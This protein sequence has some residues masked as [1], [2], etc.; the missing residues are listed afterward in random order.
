ME[1]VACEASGGPVGKGQTHRVLVN[2]VSYE[3]DL[4]ACVCVDY[5]TPT[6]IESCR[7]ELSGFKRRRA[8][9]IERCRGKAGAVMII[10]LGVEVNYDVETHGV[11]NPC[12]PAVVCAVEGYPVEG[13][14]VLVCGIIPKVVKNKRC[15]VGP[16]HRERMAVGRQSVVNHDDG[17]AEAV[18]LAGLV[19]T[20]HAA[21][22]G[23]LPSLVAQRLGAVHTVVHRVEGERQFISIQVAIVDR[24]GRCPVRI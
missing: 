7:M 24:H 3:F 16:L 18:G 21:A 20:E 19:V 5:R 23:T 17:V 12:L 1:Y 14:E 15:A 6:I 22:D 10:P 13:V 9:D 8:V 11:A 4:A 2:V